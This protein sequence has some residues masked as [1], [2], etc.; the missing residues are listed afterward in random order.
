MD[1]AVEL[2]AGAIR[3]LSLVRQHIEKESGRSVRG[4]PRVVRVGDDYRVEWDHVGL[5]SSGEFVFEDGV[6]GKIDPPHHRF[7][8]R[9]MVMADVSMDDTLQ[10]TTFFSALYRKAR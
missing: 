3:L 6:S 5:L 4:T 7:W 8:L 9:R 1:T 2:S 10:G